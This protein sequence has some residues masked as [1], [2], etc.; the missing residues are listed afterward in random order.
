MLYHNK[1]LVVLLLAQVTRLLYR[2]VL[3]ESR[4]YQCPDAAFHGVSVGRSLAF[5]LYLELEKI[6]P[7]F[8]LDDPELKVKAICLELAIS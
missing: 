7:R 2:A 3:R 6:R 1:A 4:S 8:P 5:G